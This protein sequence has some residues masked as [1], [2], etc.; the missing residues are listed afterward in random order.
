MH[1][2]RAF[3]L[4]RHWRDTPEGLELSLWAAS[5]R[6]PLHVALDREE[7]VCFVDREGMAGTDAPAR[8]RAGGGRSIWPPWRGR[9]STRSTS[10]ASATSWRRAISSA[11]GASRPSSPT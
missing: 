11:A 4:T 1:T 5:E 10:G 2:L 8:M 6:G 7:A 9:P 3:L